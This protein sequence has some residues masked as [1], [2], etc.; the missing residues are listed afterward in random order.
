MYCTLLF[1]DTLYPSRTIFQPDGSN[2]TLTSWLPN[3]PVNKGS[4]VGYL[5][6]LDLN[7]LKI[8]KSGFFNG[9]I[10]EKNALPIPLCAKDVKDLFGE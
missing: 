2:A 10:P 7:N 3:F 6:S 4:D 5:A 9:P 1:Q 8:I